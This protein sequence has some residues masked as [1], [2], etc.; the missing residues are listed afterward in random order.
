MKLLICNFDAKNTIFCPKYESS[1]ELES[2]T[3]IVVS[4]KWPPIF[5]IDTNK[6]IQ[7][8]KNTRNLDIKIEFEEK[9][10]WK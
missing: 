2:I 3:K 1:T 10:A 4:G 7:I 9:R 8:V 6:V 5:P